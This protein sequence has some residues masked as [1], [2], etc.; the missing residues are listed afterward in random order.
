MNSEEIASPH[1]DERAILPRKKW[2][3]SCFLACPTFIGER[4][5]GVEV[6]VE[7]IAGGEGGGGVLILFSLLLNLKPLIGLNGLGGRGLVLGSGGLD[8]HY[9][10]IVTL[11]LTTAVVSL[12]DD[13]RFEGV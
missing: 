13:L 3:M 6:T 12:D 2:K 7:Y 11:N 8:A 10:M 4:R 9:H 5:Q 1:V